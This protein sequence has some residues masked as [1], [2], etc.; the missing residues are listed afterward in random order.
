LPLVHDDAGDGDSAAKTARN[1][2][3]RAEHALAA[4]A[5]DLAAAKTLA[6]IIGPRVFDCPGADD[7]LPA[8]ETAVIAGATVLPLVH[9]ANL[10][11][12]LELGAIGDL[13]PGPRLAP[14]TERRFSLTSLR[15]GRRPAVLY[16]VG[17][18]PF[19]ER[20]DCDYLIAQDLY[21]PP[22]EVDAFLPSASFVEAAGTLTN[23]EGR[24]QA[25][26]RVEDLPPG[27]VYG[28]ARP[29]WQIFSEL[30]GRLGRHDL[31]YSD[32][33]A[34]RA[35]I[36]TELPGFPGED[37]RTPRRM[38]PLPPATGRDV[39]RRDDDA[40][41]APRGPGR[42]FLLVPER[43]A[44]AHRGV[45][46]AALVEGLGELGLEDGLRMSPEDIARLGIEA[47]DTVTVD[48][49]GT[50]A[51]IVVTADPNCPRG[52]VY[53]TRVQ[54]WGGLV[55]PAGDGGGQRPPVRLAALSNLP[56]RP[57]HV[58]IMA[59]DPGPSRTRR[60]PTQKEARYGPRG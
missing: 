3:G 33:A 46:L 37:D 1:R 20:P 29:D 17:E 36:R 5:R 32:D 58:R 6:I 15:E 24:V 12:A 50:R 56:P 13:L 35:A 8:L 39:E 21:L 11:G 14:K 19:T 41:R 55:P 7:L 10:R 44:F 47:G 18:T 38:T 52:T 43:A 9:G 54:A 53:A 57:V 34:V 23:L 28:Y 51:A 59:G 22:F 48:F 26:R 60:T 42:Q 40:G 27:A 25:L 2:P 30:A 4:A 31:E 45:D 16:L 49:E